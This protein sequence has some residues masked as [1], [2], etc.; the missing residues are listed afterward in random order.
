MS[1]VIDGGCLAP[2]CDSSAMLAWKAFWNMLKDHLYAYLAL[3]GQQHCTRATAVAVSDADTLAT[4]DP[5]LDSLIDRWLSNRQASSSAPDSS[6]S[7][8][9]SSSFQLV[10]GSSTADGN[11]IDVAGSAQA[12]ALWDSVLGPVSITLDS[13]STLE[14]CCII[15]HSVRLQL[16]LSL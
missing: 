14:V 4:S 8:N 7:G 15:F 9:G 1:A 11:G 16:L 2:L 6:S 10:Q 5:A 12:A 3:Q 13:L